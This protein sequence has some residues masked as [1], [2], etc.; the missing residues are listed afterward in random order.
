MLW[1]TFGR[2]GT[3]GMGVAVGAN[4]KDE[5][6]FAQQ[7]DTRTRIAPAKGF[8]REIARQGGQIPPA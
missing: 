2:A 6:C 1:V 8:G 7:S 4:M 3:I 5:N